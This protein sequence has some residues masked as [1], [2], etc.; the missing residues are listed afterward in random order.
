ME[1]CRRDRGEG[2]R[3]GRWEGGY[4]HAASIIR[5]YLEVH[6]HTC[7]LVL[8]PGSPSIKPGVPVTCC[9]SPSLRGDGEIQKSQQKKAS[10]SEDGPVRPP[11]LPYCATVCKNKSETGTPH[12][13]PQSFGCCALL[14]VFHP[15]PLKPDVQNHHFSVA[16]TSKRKPARRRHLPA[17]AAVEGPVEGF[18]FPSH[19]AAL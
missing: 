8:H 14:L 16:A 1:N 12:R 4:R 3:A 13:R 11:V 2:G 15:K 7:S 6:K 18:R 19:N 10:D 5:R 17:V 9:P